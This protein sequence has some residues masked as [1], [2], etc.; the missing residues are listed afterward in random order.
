MFHFKMLF[1]LEHEFLPREMDKL[2][3][4]FLKSAMLNYD[5]S[6]FNSFYDKSK[7]IIKQYTFSYHLQGAKF[8]DGKII[9]D[10]KEFTLLFSD[11][12]QVEMF[13]WFNAFQL[14]KLKKYPIKNNSMQLV[15]IYMQKLDEIKDNEIV[16]KIQSPLLVRRHNSND[17]SDIYYTFDTDGFES[18][19]KDN[20]RIFIERTGIDVSVDDFSI[21]TIKGKKVI[22]P[23]FGRNTDASI[24]IYKLCGSCSL[25]NVLC[26]AGLGVRRSE[27]HG[28]FKVIG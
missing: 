2:I 15:S 3:V 24:G 11:S 22:I 10:K 7:S 20:I 5:E 27:G 26:L 18:T 23:V 21:Q 13:H 28:K 6:L 14:M 1:R 9:L 17:N 19:L 4:S 16:I 25:L 8:K 12:N